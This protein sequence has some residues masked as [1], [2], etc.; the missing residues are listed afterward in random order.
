MA[1]K[2]KV[3]F[4]PSPTGYL[5][6]GSARTALFNWLFAKRYS[7][8]FILRIEDTDI[9]RS[10]KEFLEEILDSLK[11]LGIIEDKIYY[12]SQRLNLYK[13][14]AQKLID[15]KKAFYKEKAV[16]FKYEFDKVEF[17]DLIRG[18]IEFYELPKATEIL[19]KSDG[20]PTYNFSCVVDDA[21]LEITHI[22]R[23]EDHISNTPKQILL[24]KALGFRVP[25]FAHLPM[26][27]SPQGGKLSK[28]FGAT[29]V[30]EYRKKGYLAK[31]IINYLLLLGWS[32]QDNREIITLSEAAKIF[33]IKKV[34]KTA[35]SFSEEKLNWI[36]AEYIKKESISEL[37]TYTERYLRE[38]GFISKVDINYLKKVVELFKERIHKLEDLTEWAY[39]FFYDD[40]SYASDT[41][42]ILAK[43]LREEINILKEKLVSL[44]DFDREIVEKEFRH[45]AKNLGLKTRDLVHPVRV[46][47]TGRRIGPGLFETMEVLGKE[48]VI[49]RLERLIKYWGGEYA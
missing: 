29:A 5:H 14:F 3:R 40:Y 44:D 28:R 11:W 48:R 24:Y 2:L 4:A 18:R 46:A 22:I 16:I 33:D 39:C 12:Q 38:K 7:A 34:N 35:A 45:V 1:D 41:K 31:A 21:L 19:I 30:R 10:K 36:N 49:H 13:K 15:E 37:T 6:L 42:G 27:L 32:P 8:T 26:I 17:N 47:L 25:E 9:K 43:D 23:G 20:T